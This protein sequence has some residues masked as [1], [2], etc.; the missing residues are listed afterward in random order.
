MDAS[1]SPLYPHVHA[2]TLLPLCRNPLGQAPATQA[3]SE[4]AADAASRVC[5]KLETRH[6]HQNSPT[7]DP[8]Q[9]QFLRPGSSA[10]K[11]ISSSSAPTFFC[12]SRSSLKCV[13][14]R[15]SGGGGRQSQKRSLGFSQDCVYF[16]SVFLASRVIKDPT[17]R[18]F[19]QNSQD[20]G[21]E[22]GIFS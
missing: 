22:W 13:Y 12:S 18:P 4:A 10:H 3:T 21:A 8:S 2:H 6:R 11:C 5:V 14:A 19:P 17:R 9:L 16:T 1:H 20:A 7:P 15:E